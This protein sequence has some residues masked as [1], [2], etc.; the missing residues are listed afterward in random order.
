V[1]AAPVPGTEDP[2]RRG[3]RTLGVAVLMGT[4]VAVTL[5][6]AG[7]DGDGALAIGIVVAVGVAAIA[8]PSEMY[9]LVVF[10][11]I[12][13]DYHLWRFS[14]WTDQLGS[15]L[16][17][18]WWKLLSTGDSRRFGILVVNSVDVLVFAMVIGLVAQIWRG[19]MRLALSP[20]WIWGV[21]LLGTLGVM[22]LYGVA[23]GGQVRPALWQFRPLLHF[24]VF[25]LLGTQ[26][27][28]TSADVGILVSALVAATVFK[29]LQIDWI[30]FA[31]EGARFGE[32]RE[33]LGHEDSIFLAAVAT[34][35]I[36]LVLCEVRTV[37]RRLVLF[38]LP[39]V[40]TALAVNL[41]RV[42][43]VGFALSLLLMPVLLHGRRRAALRLVMSLVLAFVVYAA[44]AS[45]RPDGRFA[46]PLNKVESIFAP[47][48]ETTDA[49]S[50]LYRVAENYNLR[51]TIAAHPLGLGF[52]HPFEV[53]TPLPD[54]SFIL[55]L[56][57]Y[58]PHNAV[59]GVWTIVGSGGFVVFLSYFGIVVMLAS[60]G[61]R[62]QMD[63][64][65]IATSYF[66]L[67]SLLSGLLAA[68]TDQFLWEGRGVL[69]LGAVVAMTAVLHRDVAR[70]V[71]R[72]V[73]D[74]AESL[75]AA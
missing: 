53:E 71:C 51:R 49:S 62:W 46:M 11:A 6:L 14:P 70:P 4:L 55:P 58:I 12:L 15:Y 61:I 29:A 33:I 65:R 28:R 47:K 75:P 68:A 25:A 48:P 19:R 36:A 10:I 32:W 30:F 50:N 3:R 43:Y 57:Q 63:P 54:I 7:A 20:D 18:N 45:A 66:L 8:Y 52:G 22:L 27:L 38:A 24:V 17:N 26:L 13:A 42:A 5:A 41:R 2:R 56:W 69:F 23:A 72:V 37:Q 67:T 39:F 9:R 34:F 31:Q 35:A 21:L 40:L 16:F 74:D 60:H 59:L 1:P 73:D 44:V 64:E